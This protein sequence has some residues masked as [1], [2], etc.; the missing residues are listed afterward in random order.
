MSVEPGETLIPLAAVPDEI[1][2][3]SGGRS[4]PSRQTVYKWADRGVRGRRLATCP[5]AGAKSTRLDWL[6]E[7][8]FGSADVAKSSTLTQVR[9]SSHDAA[10]AELREMGVV[11]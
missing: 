4:R 2:R 11:S 9:N 5:G 3:M 7:F 6:R 8:V 1:A 10:M